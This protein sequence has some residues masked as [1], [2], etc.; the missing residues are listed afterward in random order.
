MIKLVNCLCDRH[1]TTHSHYI[2]DDVEICG[3]D[4]QPSSS[5]SDGGGAD[6]IPILMVLL[7]IIFVLC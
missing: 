4:D 3:I 2:K 1:K 7:I 6:M 5:Y